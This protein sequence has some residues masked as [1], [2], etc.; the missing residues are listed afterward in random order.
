[1]NTCSPT[2]LIK[3]AYECLGIYFRDIDNRITK[4]RHYLSRTH[5]LFHRSDS[6]QSG[7]FS[8]LID[9]GV[10]HKHQTLILNRDTCNCLLKTAIFSAYVYYARG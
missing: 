1:M 4:A 7:A 3:T 10:S 6:F 8:F 2:A 5:T 9:R